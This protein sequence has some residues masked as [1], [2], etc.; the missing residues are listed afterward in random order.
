MYRV[1]ARCTECDWSTSSYPLET[2]EAAVRHLR[3]WRDSIVGGSMDVVTDTPELFVGYIGTH[4]TVL[5]IE[6][7]H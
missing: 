3:E 6:E 5:R 7:A 1:L 2:R 4:V